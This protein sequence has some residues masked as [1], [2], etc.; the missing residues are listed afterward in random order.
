[1]AVNLSSGG[2]RGRK[3]FGGRSP[4][5]EINVTPLVDVMLVLLIIFMVTAPLL[6]AGVPVNLPESKAKALGEDKDQVT[7][8]MSRDGSVYL[9]DEMV[10]AGEL[11]DRLAGLPRNGSGEPPLVTLRA[12]RAL[13]YG[14]IMEVMGE[15][16]RAGFNSISLVTLAAGDSAAEGRERQKR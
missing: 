3:S 13:D 14:R 15:L 10:A 11:S 7:L 2:G 1:M 8:S 12:D 9:D 5:A 6:K 16:N 4:M